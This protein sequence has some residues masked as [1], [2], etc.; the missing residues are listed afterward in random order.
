MG[1]Y[2]YGWDEK[3]IQK[4]IMEGRGQ[5][6][7]DSYKPWLTIRDV[8]TEGRAHKVKGIKTGRVHHLLSDLE[9]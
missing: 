8:P 1:K 2:S 3:K 5:G 7:L 4:Y 9:Y 6:D